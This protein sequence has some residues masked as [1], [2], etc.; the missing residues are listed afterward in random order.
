M[1]E[2]LEVLVFNVTFNNISVISRHSFIG[3]RN[4]RPVTELDHILL[5]RVHLVM[6]GIRIRNIIGSH[7]SK[8]TIWPCPLPLWEWKVYISK[9]LTA[10]SP[11]LYL[12]IKLEKK[13]APALDNYGQSCFVRSDLKKMKC[14]CKTQM[15]PLPYHKKL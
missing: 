7:K 1:I 11:V 10:Y 9:L 12:K 3:G 8:T 5:N 15:M 4:L 6:S 2:V 14:V 13:Y